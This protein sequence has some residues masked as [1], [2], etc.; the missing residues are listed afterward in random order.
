LAKAMHD[1]GFPVEC[2]HLGF[3][4]SHQVIV[5][6]GDYEK[7]RNVAEKLQRAN[8]I[9]DCVIRFGTCEVTRRG[10]KEKEMLRVAELLKRTA[11]DEEQPNKIRKEV[12]KL[13]ADFQ[14]TEYCF[15]S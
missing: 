5:N 12:A 1:Y 14:K 13:M 9:T 8:I 7:G 4:K 10:M 2:E 11:I 15:K 6:Y 3:T